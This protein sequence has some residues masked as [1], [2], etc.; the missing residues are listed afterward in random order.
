[1]TT[2]YAN[3][4]LAEVNTLLPKRITDNI[5]RLDLIRIYPE[6]IKSPKVKAEVQEFIERAKSSY[7]SVNDLID[8]HWKLKKALIKFNSGCGEDFIPTRTINVL[9]EEYTIAELLERK[10]NVNLHR[11]L[12]N[13]LED[14][15]HAWERKLEDENRIYNQKLDTYITNQVQALGKDGKRDEASVSE[16][17]AS[18]SPTNQPIKLDPI[19]ILKEIDRLREYVSAMGD[20]G[21][22]L[23]SS[24]SRLNSTS[25]ITIHM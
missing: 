16:W 7:Q 19:N 24:L 22:K 15:N 20:K 14:I 10:K 13:K 3:D 11:L 12:L 6:V 9:G 25:Q 4:V 18:F 2:Y 21:G 17:T 1:M 5:Q 8:R 23:D